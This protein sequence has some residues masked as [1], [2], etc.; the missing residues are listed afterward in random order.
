M[1]AVWLAASAASGEVMDA[2]V[3]RAL[4]AVEEHALVWTASADGA[5]WAI[6]ARVLAV[7]ASSRWADS[8]ARLVTDDDPQVMAALLDGISWMGDD[9]PEATDF[10]W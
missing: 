8:R 5:H 4:E 10:V 2:D 6:G 7:L 3:V 1:A 9:S